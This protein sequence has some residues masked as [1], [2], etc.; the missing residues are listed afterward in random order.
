[1]KKILKAI[2]S[3]IIALYVT[4]YLCLSRF[5]GFEQVAFKVSLLPYRMGSDI[6]YRFYKKSLKAVG[7]NVYFALGTVVTNKATTIG[8]NVRLGPYTSI[9]WAHLGDDILTAQHVHILSG[10][11]QHSFSRDDIP[12]ISQ[13]GNINCVHIAGDNWIGA[14]VVVM[15]DIG[16]G[17]IIGSGSTI[18]TTIKSMCV[19]AGSPCR[20]IRERK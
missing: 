16:K 3:V 8:S 19:A 12:I 2:R 18:S 10:S 14:N 13:P 20:V 1:M 11:K 15:H 6:R 7:D 5:I 9:G 17:T 4:Y